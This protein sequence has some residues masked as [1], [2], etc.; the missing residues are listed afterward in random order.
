[1]TPLGY[2]E[3][4]L[5]KC[6]INYEREKDRGAPKEMLQNIARKIGYFEEAVKALREVAD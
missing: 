4:Q 1:M 3:R 6:R 2:M 5:A